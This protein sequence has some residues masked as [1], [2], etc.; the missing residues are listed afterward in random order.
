MKVPMKYILLGCAFF[1]AIFGFS[2]LTSYYPEILWYDS[3]GYLPIWWF[4]LKAKTGVFLG[5]FTVAFLF[6]LSNVLIA[7][8]SRNTTVSE[9]IQ[10]HPKMQV[11]E[12]LFSRLSQAKEQSSFLSLPSKIH[13]I[14][15]YF[16][17]FIVSIYF[18]LSGGAFW[19][20]FYQY[21]NPTTFGIAD[22][23]FNQD[24]SFYMFTL[25]FF[26]L[27]QGWFSKLIL[28]GLGLVIWIYLSHNLLVLLFAQKK[29]TQ[30][31]SHI[32]VLLSLLF[33]SISFGIWIKLF[34]ILYSTSGVVFGAG[35][36]DHHAQLLGYKILLGM[37]VLQSAVF[38]LWGFRSGFRIPVYSFGLMILVSIVFGNIYPGIIQSYVVAPNELVK[39]TPYIEKSIE[40]THLAYNLDKIEEKNF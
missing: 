23:I 36:A 28:I 14:A 16:A 26:K 7:R 12:Q 31:K 39:E 11:L 5:F 32:F 4:V 20:A 38:L 1:V 10:F 37:T 9:P 29:P 17:I 25:P 22:P 8:R 2:L 30:I 33:V 35:Y 27:I 21:L 18:G 40:F 13:G 34:S 15:L 19:E 24:V 3:F 6:F